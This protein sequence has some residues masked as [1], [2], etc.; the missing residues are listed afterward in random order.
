MAFTAQIIRCGMATVPNGFT[1]TDAQFRINCHSSITDNECKR[2]PP[3]SSSIA[4]RRSCSARRA[5]ARRATNSKPRSRR[6]RRSARRRRRPHQRQHPHRRRRP[7]QRIRPCSTTAPTPD[8]TSDADD[9]VVI[10]VTGDDP[11]RAVAAVCTVLGCC[12]PSR[13][14][15]QFHDENGNIT[16]GTIYCEECVTG[17]GRSAACAANPVPTFVRPVGN[18]HEDIDAAFSFM[19]TSSQHAR[20]VAARASNPQAP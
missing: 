16:T 8:S 19:M 12:R 11:N 6:R 15:A 3:R 4:R 9:A 13:R 18:T 2:R 14:T 1:N 20:A 17:D 7:Q 10:G 5:S